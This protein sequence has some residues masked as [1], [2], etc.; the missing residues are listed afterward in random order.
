M[1]VQGFASIFGIDTVELVIILAI[2]L[3]LFGSK[4]LTEFAKSASSTA[5]G[6]GDKV[7]KSLGTAKKPPGKDKSK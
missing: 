5:K 4:R 7:S 2:I 1:G 6:L 3:L